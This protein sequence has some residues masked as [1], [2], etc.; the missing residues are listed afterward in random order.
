MFSHLE[1]ICMKAA[2]LFTWPRAMFSFFK[3]FFCISAITANAQTETY[4][5]KNVAIG[6]GGFVTGIITSK[7]EANLM[8]A[9]TDVGGAYRWNSA[10]ST[11]IPLLDWVGE[12]EVGY[13]GVESIAID[14]VNPAKMYMLVGTSYFNSGKT[15]I[16]RSDDYGNTFQIVDVTSQFKAH[17]NGMGRQTGEKLVVDPNL[18]ST[19]YVGTRSNGL[20]KSTNSGVSWSRVNSLNITTTVSGNGVS[21]VLIDSTGAG[22]GVASSII[23]AGISQTGSNLYLSTDGGTTF[24]AVAGS[25]STL[26]PHRAVMTSNRD[27]YI[28]YANKEGPWNIDGAGAIW[29][30]SLTTGIW[31]NVTP[32]GFTAS[33]GGISV[34]PE[35]PLRLVASSINKYVEQEGSW[36]DRIFLSVNGGATWTD[37]VARGFQRDENGIEW[38]TGHA[39]HWAGCVE[40]DPFN[41]KKAWI[42]SGNGVFQTD[43]ID[44]TTNVWKFQVKGMEETVPLDISSIPNG[45]LLSAIGDYDGFIH[46]DVASYAKVHQPQM[47][48]TTSIAYASLHPDYMARTGE[49]FYVSTN[50]G[51]S[52]S[53]VTAQGKKG[54]VSISAD[55]KTLLHSPEGVSTTYRSENH[56]T[57]WSAVVG[58][59]L[60]NARPVADPLNPQKFYVYNSTG[61]VYISS[62]GGKTF[63]AGGSA[64]SNG[65]KVIRLAPYREGD[66][67]IP[68]FN[69]GLT[70]SVNGGESFTKVSSVTSCS[71]VG[72]GKHAP[73]KEYPTVFIWGTVNGVT[74]VHRSIDE[75]TSW[76]RVNDDSHEY[77]GLAN[78]Q[79]ILGDMNVFGRVFMS[80]AGRGIVYGESSQTCE[81][82]RLTS[83]V[84]INDA[85]AV[86][87]YITVNAGSV[88]TLTVQSSTPG[89][90]RWTGP[91]S[92]SHSENVYSLSEVNEA[93]EGLYSGYFEGEGCESAPEVFFLNV[94]PETILVE[95]ITVSSENGSDA[96]TTEGG[97]LQL[98]TQV[99]PAN[100]TNSQITWSITSGETLATVSD[101]GLVTAIADG[102]ITVRAT[103]ADGSTVFDEIEIEITNQNVTGVEQL[104]SE[105]FGIYPIPVRDLLKV[106]NS[107][108]I[109]GI[110]VADMK[111][112]M[113]KALS[114]TS[115]ELRSVSF[116]DLPIGMYVL[117]IIDKKGRVYSLKVVKE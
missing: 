23:I 68:V 52:W 86:S 95:S 5:W 60:S 59:S 11:W 76:V 85:A 116:A 61:T 49:K 21:F 93:H 82:V 40:F 65:S 36:G 98:Q 38:V 91:G 33:Y 74:G 46:E 84:S 47:G 94:I 51:V 32:T 1:I 57:T 58:L 99:L 55:G 100:A 6:G 20:F 45:P 83:T 111:G 50:R 25:P 80:T 115:S 42:I 63:T 44:A 14:P 117:R 72:F 89:T 106:D 37:V 92:I 103:A 88:V 114:K 56:G 79:F 27:V 34:D 109:N 43:D 110:S 7:V 26:M 81:P 18:P 22:S 53:Q 15:A 35:N 113:I 31:T 29:K 30:Y 17:G 77:G 112:C 66:L 48:T 9:R 24:T 13:L 12:N 75:G 101:N 97:T 73:G 108:L 10:T 105:K 8:Y 69:G 54:Y 2:F 3:I 41:T 90:F 28:T 104:I 67:W 87:R 78:G 70:R 39:I 19:L 16:L 71:A 64:G 4:S 107:N 62:D 96:I 102:T